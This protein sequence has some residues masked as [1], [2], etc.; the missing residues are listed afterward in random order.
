MFSFESVFGEVSSFL[1]RLFRTI[2]YPLFKPYKFI[3]EVNNN[4]GDY[5]GSNTFLYLSCIGVFFMHKLFSVEEEFGF[6]DFEN[7]VKVFNE[8]SGK[9]I[10]TYLI[11]AA[12]IAAFV[13][14]LIRII[15]WL[16]RLNSSYPTIKSLA[17]YWF[18]STVLFMLVGLVSLIF[19]A[20]LFNTN[21][22][23]FPMP[24]NI[25][26]GLA[27]IGFFIDNHLWLIIINLF[28]GVAVCRFFSSIILI[29][30][31]LLLAVVSL[32]SFYW[33]P[34]FFYDFYRIND[35]LVKKDT[36]RQKILFIGEELDSHLS[37]EI[38]ANKSD[39][40]SF[41]I[42]LSVFKI[43]SNPVLLKQK[44]EFNFVPLK[45]QSQDSLPSF[46]LKADSVG[47]KKFILIKENEIADLTLSGRVAIPKEK[48][49]EKLSDKLFDVTVTMVGLK[50]GKFLDTIQVTDRVFLKVA[51]PK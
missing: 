39:S 26:A 14:V 50:K 40:C 19:T 8:I 3:N 35:R 25:Y 27:F 7:H 48:L 38:S 12:P 29:I 34:N 43:G 49:S 21:D 28:V 42:P 15:T 30:K 9:D 44:A 36:N 16:L 2:F 45:E 24:A 1:K 33:N 20:F 11:T 51:S 23:I 32:N 22:G 4:T 37:I 10:L 31:V 18:G 47:H 6:L 46:S 13:Y 41:S 17:F 5:I